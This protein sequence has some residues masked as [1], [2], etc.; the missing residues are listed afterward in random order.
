MKNTRHNDI[1]LEIGHKWIVY[2]AFRRRPGHLMNIL[3]AFNLRH[4]SRGITASHVT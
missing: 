2:K 4:V 3:L 1:T